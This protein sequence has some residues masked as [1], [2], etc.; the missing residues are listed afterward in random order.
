M[1]R[2][3]YTARPAARTRAAATA[4]LAGA[5]DR[6]HEVH[7]QT[8]R[9]PT[10]AADRAWLDGLLALQLPAAERTRLHA[11]GQRMSTMESIDL[12]FDLD[13]LATI[14]SRSA[15]QFTTHP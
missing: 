10:E 8:Q 15:P 1:L 14:G 11:E 7:G 6:E 4:R 12:A 13:D 9:Q 5:A 3:N 2:E